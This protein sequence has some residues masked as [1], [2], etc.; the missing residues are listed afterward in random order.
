[1]YIYIYDATSQLFNVIFFL[2][3]SIKINCTEIKYKS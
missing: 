2:L 3:N 1:M